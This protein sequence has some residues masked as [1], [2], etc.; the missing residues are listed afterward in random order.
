M[1]VGSFLLDSIKSTYK[2]QCLG[3]AVDGVRW[4][5][6]RILHSKLHLAKGCAKD[7]WR[8]FGRPLGNRRIQVKGQ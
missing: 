2:V 3:N 1:L 6:V 8:Y 4:V 5:L 7:M